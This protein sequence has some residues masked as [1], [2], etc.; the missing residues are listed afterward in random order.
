MF[1]VCFQ[2]Y[3]IGL[4]VVIQRAPFMQIKTR[5]PLGY[6]RV[7]AWASVVPVASQCTCGY[8]Y[9]PVCS[10][11]ANK[12][13]IAIGRPLGDSISQYCSS[14]A[15]GVEVIM[16]GHFPACKPLCMQPVWREMFEV[17]WFHLHC[18]PNYTKIVMMLISKACTKWYWNTHTFEEQIWYA[19][20]LIENDIQVQHTFQYGIITECQ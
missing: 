7:L 18:N 17:S 10:N 15:S 20:D 6:R 1:P 4:P 2:W 16:S 12:H 8:S 9:L 14:A 3:S 13:W 19:P 11:Y 5:L